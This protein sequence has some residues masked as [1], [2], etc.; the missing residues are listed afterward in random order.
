MDFSRA[1]D[2]VGHQR[3]LVKL[4]Y[5]GIEGKTNKWI[6]S[7]LADRKQTVVLEGERSYEADVKSGVPQGSVLGPCL[8]LFYINDLPQSLTSTV[9]LFADDTI[10][11]L[12]IQSQSD[13]ITLQNDLNKLGAWEKLWQMEFH[14]DKCQVLTI[15]RKRQPIHHE[16]SLHGHILQHVKSAKY[17]GVTFDNK[18]CWND[19][20]NQVANKASRSLGFLRRNLRIDSPELK[21]TAYNALVRPLVEYAPTVWDPYTQKNKHRLEMVQRRAAR[22]VLRR[23]H[24]TSSVTDMLHELKWETLEERRRQQRLTMMYKIHNGLVAVNKDAYMCPATRLS[25][26]NNPLAYMI[27]DTGPDYYNQSYFPRTIREW[28]HL[29]TNI[30]KATTLDSFKSRLSA[31]A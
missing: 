22:Y 30:V 19:H 28:N 15:T 25:K 23:Y 9:R 7:F 29:P 17:L 16:Y 1:F 4:K 24:N 10:A 26:S 18:L 27:P 31:L 20:I 3:L 6:G 2:K 21:T 12:T 11:Y 13:A 14:P 8:F 5:Y